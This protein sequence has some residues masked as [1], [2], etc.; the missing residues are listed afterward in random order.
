MQHIEL[1]SKDSS[2]CLNQDPSDEFL[3]K[4]KFLF[5][6]EDYTAIVLEYCLGGDIFQYLKKHDGKL[7]LSD[8][9]FYVAN[10]ILALERLHMLS[11]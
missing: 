7:C 3:V 6:N 2:K 11:I 1:E 4:R 10:V 9:K 5:K 8:I